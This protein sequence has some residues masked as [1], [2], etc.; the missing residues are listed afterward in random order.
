MWSLKKIPQTAHFYWGNDS[1]SFLRYLTVLS[2]KKLNPD[3]QIKLYYPKIKYEGENTWETME[4]CRKFIGQNYM[5]KLFELNIDRIEVDFSELGLDSHIPEA[6]KSD[7]WRWKI[8]SEE[9]G[10]W[11]DFDIIY[12]K[13]MESLYFNNV[14]NNEMN[15]GVC[16]EENKEGPNHSIGFLL[17]SSGNDFY[18]F[19]RDESESHLDLKDYQSIG[20]IMFNK[21]FPT[22]MSIEQKFP[23]L[24]PINIKMDV[25]YPVHRHCIYIPSLCPDIDLSGFAESTIG[26]HW[27]AGYPYGVEWEN[28]ITESNY[29]D[30]EHILCKIIGKVLY[31]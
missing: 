6:L 30:Y 13:T 9:G 26:L 5:D 19:I 4:H 11:S 18:K 20:A 10:L 22:I 15:T 23:H 31:S 1:I 25:V 8:L 3:W 29:R 16:I 21:Y 2:F 17:S 12:F 14:S 27:Y 7:L 24:N 28:L